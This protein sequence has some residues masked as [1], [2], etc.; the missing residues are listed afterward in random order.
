[1][2]KN[3]L[4]GFIA[5]AAF[6]YFSDPDRGRRR[7]AGARDKVAA[8]WRDVTKELDKAE[9]DVWNRTRGVGA[10]VSSLWN[11]SEV[12][13][14]VLVD[15]VRSRIGRVVSH[16][17]AIRARAETDG[18]IILEGPVLQ[19]E[20]DNLLKSVRATP[21]V[22]EV[23][24]RLE[25]HAEPEGV[26]SLQGGVPRLALSEFAQQR[27]TPALRVASAALAGG[28]LYE[29]I[30]KDG[31]MSWLSSFAG[32]LLMARV[33]ANRPF[34]QIVGVGSGARGVSFEKTIHIEAP[35]EEVY[36]YWANFENFPKF[37]SHLKRVRHLKNGR[38]HWVAAGPGGVSIPWDAEITEQRPNQLLAWRSVPESMIRTEG[39]ARFDR[40]PDGRTRVQIRM[41]YC[42]PTGVLGHAVAWVFGADPKTEMDEDLVRLKSLLENGR[43]RAHGAVITRDQISIPATGQL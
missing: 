3:A 5:G 27:W 21:G 9:R 10:A 28:F 26:S 7:R 12:D 2:R 40:E 37:M 38:S 34:R 13:G 39:V 32:G 11:N 35:I 36:G 20:L 23:I 16:P 42:P 19:Y 33:I 25:V 18:R 14:D 24:N 31:L 15:R 43:T 1:M 4:T 30:R 17:R 22:V 6:M 29:G 8:R 41:S